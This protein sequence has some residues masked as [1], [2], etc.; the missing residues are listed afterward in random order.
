M[1]KENE[2]IQIEKF[3]IHCSTLQK[4]A[5]NGVYY[6]RIFP[7]GNWCIIISGNGQQK[8]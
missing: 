6:Q 4:L 3:L 5:F 1:T 7:N 2:N 8:D